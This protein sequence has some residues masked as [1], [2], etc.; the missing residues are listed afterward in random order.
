[1]KTTLSLAT[2]M[3]IFAIIMTAANFMEG[4]KES[5]T[6]PIDGYIGKHPRHWD[7]TFYPKSLYTIEEIRKLS[8][9]VI[10]HPYSMCE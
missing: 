10:L 1:M 7:H 4:E 2:A 5:C 8:P 3:S 6:N 9:D